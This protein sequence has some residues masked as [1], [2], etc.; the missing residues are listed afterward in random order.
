M[1]LS[2]LFGKT[3]RQVPAEAETPSHRLLLRAGMVQQV[4]AGVYAYMPLGWAVFRKIERIIREEM[5]REGGQEMMMPSIV[6]IEVYQ[7]SGR[8]QTMKDIL[9]RLSDGRGREFA[10]GPTHEELFTEVFK[11]NVRSYRDLPLLAYQIAPKFRDEPRPRGGLIRLRQFWMKDLYSFDADW[12]GLDISYRKMYDA[13]QR[14]FDRCAVPTVPVLADSG[15]MGGKDT[16]QFM[17]VTEY[18]E[19]NCLFCPNCGYAADAE[20][21]AFVKEPAHSSEEAKPAEE[22][23]TPGLYTIQTLAQHLGV[24][25][26]RTCKA[27]FYQATYADGTESKNQGTRNKERGTRSEGQGTRAEAVFVAIRGDM[28][29]NESKLRKALGAVDVTYMSEEDAQQAG[30]VAGSASAVGLAG[31][32]IVA[33]DLL[34]LEHNLVAGANKPDKH[35]L[36]VNYQRDWT[37]DVVADIALAK[38]G[39]RCPNCRTPM[40]LKRGIEMGQVFKLGTRYAED[41][42]AVFQDQE[43]KQRPAVM[44]SYGIGLERLL[45]GVIEANHDESGIIW[46]H[47]LAPYKVHIVA[48]QPEKPEVAQ[49]ADRLYEELQSLG[50]E[51]LYDDREETPGVK[52]NDADLLGMPLRTTLSPRNLSSGS[53]EVKARTEAQSR[54]IPLAEAAAAL[55]N[56]AQ[57]SPERV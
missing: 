57:Q 36:N 29:V 5:D 10:L 19:D 16:H 50:V 53:A 11:R 52:F 55:A 44:G 40:D 32:R 2:Q 4:A 14:I 23:D 1:R 35:L 26:S 21:A 49:A 39:Y 6:P 18:G 38:E 34:P 15:A 37:A 8:D 31:A 46:P 28:D 17:Y 45:A 13:Y 27:V 9:F 48:I 24:P 56:E 47:E 51:V 42:G 3:L 30:F 25:E 22:I 12:E 7:Q 20:V 54:L 33:D 43:G 41:I